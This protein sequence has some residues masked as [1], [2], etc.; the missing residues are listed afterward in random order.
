MTKSRRLKH[1]REE[2]TF[3]IKTKPR[4]DLE[5]KV[6]ETVDDCINLHHKYILKGHKKKEDIKLIEKEV[7]IVSYVN[8]LY[9]IKLKIHIHTYSKITFD[10]LTYLVKL[11]SAL[12]LD[13]GSI[14]LQQEK[15]HE[16][17]SSAFI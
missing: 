1:A 9:H 10:F 16:K 14:T 7:K 13:P 8:D 3:F 2:K 11:N 5:F 4:S 17:I 15:H 12:E 6:I